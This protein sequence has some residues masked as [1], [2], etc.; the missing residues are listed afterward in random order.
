MH[1]TLR[2]HIIIFADARLCRYKGTNFRAKRPVTFY[3]LFR[4]CVC[5]LMRRSSI[6]LLLSA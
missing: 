2:T 1:R 6:N 5:N 3:P 4:L